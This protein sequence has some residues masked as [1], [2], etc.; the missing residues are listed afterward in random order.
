MTRLFSIYRAER[1]VAN[2][3]SRRSQDTAIELQAS[4]LYAV[5]G[6]TFKTSRISLDLNHGLSCKLLTVMVN[7]SDRFVRSKHMAEIKYPKMAL[8]ACACS[9]RTT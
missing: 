8:G 6:D 7:S 4:I 9:T 2:R 3:L 5:Y 1:I